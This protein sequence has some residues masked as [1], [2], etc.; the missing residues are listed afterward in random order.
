M[1][2]LIIMKCRIRQVETQ[3]GLL[4]YPEYKKYFKW[5]MFY[6]ETNNYI[7]SLTF[8]DA[9]KILQDFKN[10]Y[11]KPNKTLNTVFYLDNTDFHI[12]TIVEELIK[13]YE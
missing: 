4:F 10:N 12:I 2:K 9:K 13:N 1:E 3:D 6:D 7:F 5:K 8:D 11:E